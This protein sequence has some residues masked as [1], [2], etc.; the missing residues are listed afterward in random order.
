MQFPLLLTQQVKGDWRVKITR[1][2]QDPNASIGHVGLAVISEM[3]R[4]S[5]LN[6]L[7]QKLTTLEQPQISD[8]EILRTLCGLLCQGKTGALR[9]SE[10]TFGASPRC[11]GGE[12]ILERPV[13]DGTA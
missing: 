11:V 3:A 8:A 4:V 12:H 6:D 10:K 5:G 13:V 1:V 7:C 2:E 9:V